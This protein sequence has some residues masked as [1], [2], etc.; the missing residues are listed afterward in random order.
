MKRTEEGAWSEPKRVDELSS[1]G[2]EW[3]PTMTGAG[4]IYF[5][6]ERRQGNRGTPGT[7]DIWRSRLVEG[8]FTRPE[9]LGAAINTT[10]NDIEPYI[11]PDDTFMIFASN[12]FPDTRGSYDLY[13]SYH[14][15]GTWT[16]AEN[17]G[18][19]INSPGWDFSPRI[20]PD[21][22]YLFFTSNRGFTDRP[23]ERRLSYEEL[24]DKL[25][26]P[27]NGLRDIYQVDLSAL[28]LKPGC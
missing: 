25:H 10:G 11:S 26:G 8:R 6:S 27:G 7:S 20:S 15:N 24:L 23:L 2:N 22:R 17:L 12:G 4:A 5:G 14:C 28:N 19:T 9:N 13:V 1:E 21:G 18:D 3:Y 16:K